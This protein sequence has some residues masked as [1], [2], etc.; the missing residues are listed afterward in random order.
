MLSR[1]TQFSLIVL[2]LLSVA[3]KLAA[4]ARGYH[5]E[6]TD[7]TT[8]YVILVNDSSKTIEAFHLSATCESGGRLGGS[9]SLDYD[10]L[11]TWGSWAAGAR[12]Q[13]GRSIGSPQPDVI[14]PGR[15]MQT[16][17]KLL[18][19]PSGCL[20]HADIDAVIYSDG[21]Y[22]GS[23]DGVLSLQAW[24]D[25]FA[26]EL[27]FWSTRLHQQD[28]KPF[29][30][31][32]VPGEAKRR[33]DA[34][35]ALYQGPNH[36]FLLDYKFGERQVAGNLALIPTGNPSPDEL[37]RIELNF[38]DQWQRKLDDDVAFKK[39]KLIFP[40]P[41]DIVTSAPQAPVDSTQR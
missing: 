34:D 32:A 21:T 31:Y 3:T 1:R 24:R 41:P 4:Q 2:C 11:W 35:M 7:G 5:M 38:I 33:A 6:L 17:T 15:R 19:Q 26:D 40:L 13:N 22:E 36:P 12:D 37:R 14:A 16:L 25:G 30:P 29:D 9:T 28:S 18:P 39:M 27:Q 10:K 23:N 8:G 20:W